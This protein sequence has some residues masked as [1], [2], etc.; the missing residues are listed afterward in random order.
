MCTPTESKAISKSHD[1]TKEIE[2][3]FMGEGA[4]SGGNI[5]DVAAVNK[6][7][8]ELAMRWDQEGKSLKEVRGGRRWG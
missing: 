8:K 6:K 5:L 3:A 4:L 2:A 7:L 1:S